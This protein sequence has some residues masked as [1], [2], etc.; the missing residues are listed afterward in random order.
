MTYGLAQ[1]NTQHAM[2]TDNPVYTPVWRVLGALV[3]AKGKDGRGQYCYAG[4]T[5]DWLS[6]EQAKHFLRLKVVEP[7][8]AE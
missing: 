4:D 7:I 5:L 1:R 3:I 6:D 2:G 8:D